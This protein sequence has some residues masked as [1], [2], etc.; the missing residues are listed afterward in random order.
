MISAHS[1][2]VPFKKGMAKVMVEKIVLKMAVSNQTERGG[3]R[4]KRTLLQATIAVILLNQAPLSHDTF[5]H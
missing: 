4:D 3:A 5:R 2:L 1:V